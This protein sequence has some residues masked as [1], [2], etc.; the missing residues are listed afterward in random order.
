[1]IIKQRSTSIHENTK[2]SAAKIPEGI[3]TAAYLNNFY[4]KLRSMF[5]GRKIKI[6]GFLSSHLQESQSYSKMSPQKKI[7]PQLLRGQV[8]RL[9]DNRGYL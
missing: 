1:M 6:N 7:A 3:F 5:L 9:R 2:K 8:S 4:S